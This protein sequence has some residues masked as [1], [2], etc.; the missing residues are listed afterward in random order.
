MKVFDEGYHPR[1]AWDPV[2]NPEMGNLHWNSGFLKATCKINKYI[3]NRFS[4][5][6]LCSLLSKVN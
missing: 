1:H 5:Y 2:F 6:S 4:E 3:R